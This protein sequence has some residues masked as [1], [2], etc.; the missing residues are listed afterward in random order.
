MPPEHLRGE[1]RSWAPSG[2]HDTAATP[3]S[4]ATAGA[5]GRSGGRLDHL[6]NCPHPL[7]DLGTPPNHPPSGES[8]MGLVP[9]LAIRGSGMVAQ[10]GLQ[11]DLVGSSP[12]SCEPSCRDGLLPVRPS[13]GPLEW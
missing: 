11:A 8:S 5:A 10:G 2:G 9:T 6:S 3:S 7:G 4:A 12:L 13:A 1:H